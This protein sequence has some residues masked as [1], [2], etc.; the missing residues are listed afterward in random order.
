[1]LRTFK[2]AKLL[3]VRHLLVFP[4]GMIIIPYQRLCLA[5]VECVNDKTVDLVLKAASLD[6]NLSAQPFDLF[7]IITQRVDLLFESKNL[8][9]LAECP[10]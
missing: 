3:N 9:R 1:M 8:G 2:K 7:A 10:G 6:D 4:M 5:R